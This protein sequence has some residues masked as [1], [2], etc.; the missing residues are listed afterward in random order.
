MS[1][2]NVHQELLVW[3][4]QPKLLRSPREHSTEI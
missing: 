1:N 3:L 4:K 2:A